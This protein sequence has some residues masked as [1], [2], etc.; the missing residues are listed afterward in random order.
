MKKFIASFLVLSTFLSLCACNSENT[1]V[2]SDTN[3]VSNSPSEKVETEDGNDIKNPPETEYSDVKVQKIGS[4]DNYAFI[5]NDYTTNKM[6]LTSLDG[7]FDSGA[8]YYDVTQNSDG[9]YYARTQD[10]DQPENLDA[11]NSINLVDQHGNTLIKGYSDYSKVSDR[12][13]VAA[14]AVAVLKDDSDYDF[15]LS[16]SYFS[17]SAKEGD[18]KYNADFYVYDIEAKSFLTGLK[19]E[20]SPYAGNFNGDFI[21]YKDASGSNKIMNA[22][23]DNLPDGAVLLYDSTDA[24]YKIETE[25]EGKVYDSKMNELFSY[26]KETDYVPYGFTN[27]YFAARKQS[28]SKAALLDKTG[29]AVSAE[30]SVPSGASVT[31]EAYGKSILFSTS[32]TSKYQICKFNGEVIAESENF[33]GCNDRNY[34]DEPLFY[35]F[36]SSKGDLIIVSTAGEIL[37]EVYGDTS[38][39][40]ESYNCV[41]QK[42]GEDYYY[43]NLKDKKFNIKAEKF[44]VAPYLVEVKTADNMREIIDT[45]TGEVIIDGYSKYNYKVDGSDIYVYAVEDNKTDIYLV[46]F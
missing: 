44:S 29:K 17:L 30:F 10:Y 35:T 7:K 25:T 9:L 3:G 1:Q 34:F 28:E 42:S 14:K 12:F 2:Q 21:T 19:F 16:N 13:I 39:E 8:I 23:G 11:I 26:N 31:L 38:Y 5:Y 18:T 46:R 45:S 4:M 37:F 6:G 41:K 27:G 33:I 24:Y 36:Y 20:D 32:K 40:R 15:Y 43:F 22:D